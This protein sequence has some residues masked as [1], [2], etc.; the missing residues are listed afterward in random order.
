MLRECTAVHWLALRLQSMLLYCLCELLGAGMLRH[1][2]CLSVPHLP[3]ESP[4]C[5][6]VPATCQ[7][8]PPTFLQ[9]LLSTTSHVVLLQSLRAPC[10]QF[11]FSTVNKKV[12]ED[13]GKKKLLEHTVYVPKIH[14]NITRVFEFQIRS[15]SLTE[16]ELTYALLSTC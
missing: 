10:H 6:T 11:T 2:I 9:L 4:Q 1:F 13:L 14:F 5:N 12:T 8:K 3:S 15:T 16:S 7:P